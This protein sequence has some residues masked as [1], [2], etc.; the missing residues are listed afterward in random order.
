MLGKRR[1][2]TFELGLDEKF[3]YNKT[4]DPSIIASFSTAAFRFGHSMIDPIFTKTNPITGDNVK[5]VNVSDTLFDPTEYEGTG[6]EMILKGMQE[7]LAQARDRFVTGELSSRL[8]KDKN[9]V[10]LEDSLSFGQ[11]L[12]AR[13]IAR[14]R[15]H[16]IPGYGKFMQ[17]FGRHLWRSTN[18]W[19]KTP[20]HFWVSSWRDLEKL[21]MSPNDID[22]YTGGLLERR[23]VGEGPLGFMFGYII[24]EQFRRLKYG[25]RFFFTNVGMDMSK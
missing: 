8:F 4:V 25:D 21:Y 3:Q 2:R 10:I 17:K 1:M 22:L 20:V 16:G 14:G 24:A 13:N 6:M 11:D 18:N 5:N 15:D 19:E 12:N 9:K 23:I 7:N